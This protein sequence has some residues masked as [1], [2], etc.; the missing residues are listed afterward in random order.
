MINELL[1]PFYLTIIEECP[2]M[3]LQDLKEAYISN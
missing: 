2:N 1:K 3:A